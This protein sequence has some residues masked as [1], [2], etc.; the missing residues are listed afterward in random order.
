MRLPLFIPDRLY[1]TTQT[2]TLNL[3]TKNKSLYIACPIFEAVEF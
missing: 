2:S 1:V 3:N